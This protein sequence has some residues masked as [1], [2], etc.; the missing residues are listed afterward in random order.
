M[1]DG[2]YPIS[3]SLSPSGELLA[4]SY[5]YVDAGVVKS[6]VVFYNF[7]PVGANQS[8]YMVSAYT[9]SDLVVPK[10]QFMN[11]DT[12]SRQVTAA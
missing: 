2:G 11:N 8:D 9:Y 3:I 5:L 10:V 1:D 12:P 7:G 4:V 6:N